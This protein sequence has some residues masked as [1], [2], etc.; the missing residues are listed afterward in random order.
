MD[1]NEEHEQNSTASQTK[2]IIGDLDVLCRK[3]RCTNFVQH[4]KHQEP[5]GVEV[6]LD[7]QDKHTWIVIDVC[8]P[9]GMGVTIEVTPGL[10]VGQGTT[11][12]F[13]CWGTS[14]F[15]CTTSDRGS[16]TAANIA[17]HRVWGILANDIWRMDHVELLGGILSSKGQNRQLSAWML[18]Q[19]ACHVQHLAINHDP[20]I[21]LAVVLGHF[22]HGNT[23]ATTARRR[24]CHDGATT[25][26]AADHADHGVRSVFANHIW[27]MDH[28]EFL[29]GILASKG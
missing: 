5:G 18:R 16:N 24:P 1:Y 15:G 22:C 19:E 12:V 3:D 13:P 9:V 6:R 14:R 28:V 11:L 8:S 10:V 25:S 21:A 20:A 2:A 23:S 17:D 7:V 27:G 26:A 29:C 4:G